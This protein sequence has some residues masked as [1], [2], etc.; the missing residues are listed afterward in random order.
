MKDVLRIANC[1]G[2]YGDR[3]LAAREMVDGGPIDVLT[4]DYLAELTMSILW[5]TRQRDPDRGYASTFVTQMEHVLGTAR[6]RHQ[7]FADASGINPAGSRTL[8]KLA[9]DIR[10]PRG[11]AYVVET[12][13]TTLGIRGDGHG[14]STWTPEPLGGSAS[15]PHANASW[16]LGN[17]RALA[18]GA[19]VVITRRVDRC[20]PRV[21]PS[22]N[23]DWQP[24]H[25]ELWLSG[26]CR[27]ITVRS[28]APAAIT[29]LRR[30]ARLDRIGFPIAESPD[31]STGHQHPGTGGLVS[32]GP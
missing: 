10:R 8:A 17:Q 15:S 13:A 19:E 11:I 16:R 6:Q 31:G 12:I 3:L 28:S 4:G 5:R 27:P 7:S 9:A 23:F 18:A 22:L 25:W 20:G 29:H 14:S 1:S 24:R 30:R 32:S 26:R 2:F 21:G